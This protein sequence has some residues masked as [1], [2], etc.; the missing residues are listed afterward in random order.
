MGMVLFKE[1]DFLV[2]SRPMTPYEPYPGS[3]P[4][5]F[6]YQPHMPTPKVIEEPGVIPGDEWLRNIEGLSPM[7]DYSI[8]RLGGRTIQAPFYRYDFL[9]DYPEILL[10]QGRNCL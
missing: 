2:P 3:P 9:P 7:H 10:S 8:P 1:L 6:N 5:N 4:P